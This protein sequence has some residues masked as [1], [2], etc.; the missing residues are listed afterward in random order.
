MPVGEPPA[1]ISG[2]WWGDF[3]GSREWPQN[4]HRPR[5]EG[6]WWRWVQCAWR[7]L[8]QGRGWSGLSGPP[9]VSQANI[10]GGT[11]PIS[12]SAATSAHSKLILPSRLHIVR[13]GPLGVF[14]ME[15]EGILVPG[16]AL[17]LE[18]VLVARAGTPLPARGARSPP[19]TRGP[20]PRRRAR[21]ARH[22]LRAGR[23]VVVLA[24]SESRTRPSRAAKPRA[25]ISMVLGIPGGTRRFSGGVGGRRWG[26][27]VI[28]GQIS[29]E[30]IRKEAAMAVQKQRR[31]GGG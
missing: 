27:C 30:R 29:P 26:R 1:W 6:L 21:R 8:T 10:A 18:E 25:M 13:P 7:W 15:Q 2:Q 5:D 12:G 4:R 20:G 31:L 9:A 24:A 28:T 11:S 3:G 23:G 17:L 14:H 19:G 22:G 16:F